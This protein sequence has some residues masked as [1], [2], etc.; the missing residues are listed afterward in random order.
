MADLMI[1]SIIFFVLVGTLIIAGLLWL[2]LN[3]SYTCP[4][5]HKVWARQDLS[6]ETLGI[7]QKTIQGWPN[8]RKDIG[9][10]MSHEKYR[11]YHRCK[12]CGYEWDSIGSRRL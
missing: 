3:P 2:F 9:K 7:F 5:C 1:S 8:N 6:E 12:Y 4:N 11:R 10:L